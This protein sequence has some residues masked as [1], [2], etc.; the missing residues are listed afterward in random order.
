MSAAAACAMYMK[1][2]CLTMAASCK[3]L[4]KAHSRGKA[5]SIYKR[6]S[7]VLPLLFSRFI[8]ND[9]LSSTMALL[10]IALCCSKCVKSKCSWFLWRQYGI[11]ITEGSKKAIITRRGDPG[12]RRRLAINRVSLWN[13][14]RS[15]IRFTQDHVRKYSQTDARLW[16]RRTSTKIRS[17]PLMDQA[18]CYPFT[19]SILPI[20]HAWIVHYT[21][22]TKKMYFRK[23]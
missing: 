7:A 18:F 21:G 14:P 12:H 4:A 16:N 10:L 22:N 6:L 5:A 8:T 2:D 1:L 11:L 15:G 20:G 9:I 23:P 3:P 19:Y 13:A 17:Q